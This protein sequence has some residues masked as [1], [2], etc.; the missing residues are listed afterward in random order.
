M[1]NRLAMLLWATDPAQPHLCATP[2]F[3]AATAAAMDIEVEMYFTSRSVKL[4]AAGV[5]A[6]LPSGPR[7]R[8][9]VY[10][11]MQR[12]SEMGVKFY[13]CPQAMEEH[14]VAQADFVREVTGVAGAAAFLGRC[15]DESW[16]TITY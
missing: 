13:A 11:F 5:A 12:A 16:V 4:L 2:F 14:A 1:K 7:Q 15:M 3:H 10:A 8:D 9:T 6:A